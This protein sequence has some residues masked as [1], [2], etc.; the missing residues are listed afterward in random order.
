MNNVKNAEKAEQ[1]FFEGYACAQSVL[2]TYCEKY[3]LDKETAKKISSTFG[4]G[5]GRLR[6]K[7]GALTGA[8]MVLGLEYG[9]VAPNDME[10]KL[11]AYRLVRKLT[12]RFKDMHDE[13]NC[14]ALLKKY[15]NPD[16]ISKRTHHKTICH[17]LV[18]DT[19]NILD[20]IMAS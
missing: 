7:C 8:F 19:V 12:K 3:N 6:K 16:E 11:H 13:T 4:G 17:K 20:E 5:M 15:S 1:L 9:N 10:K 18:Y 2:L 14:S